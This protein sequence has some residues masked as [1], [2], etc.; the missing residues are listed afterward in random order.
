M[1][2]KGYNYGR[3][4]KLIKPDASQ[5]M[6]SQDRRSRMIL[7]GETMPSNGKFTWRHQVHFRVKRGLPQTTFSHPQNLEKYKM[8]ILLFVLLLFRTLDR[9][10]LGATTLFQLQLNSTPIARHFHSFPGIF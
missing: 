2:G 6:N 1:A 8:D 3:R 5:I 4:A 10:N 9:L 7:G